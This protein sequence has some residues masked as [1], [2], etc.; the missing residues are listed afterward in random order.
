MLSSTQR[1]LLESYKVTM[2]TKNQDEFQ[3]H[4]KKAFAEAESEV[5]LNCISI[6]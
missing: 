3:S 6:T 1:A 4:L 2:A 5:G